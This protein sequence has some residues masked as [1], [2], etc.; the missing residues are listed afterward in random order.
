MGLYFSIV[1]A[2][3]LLMLVIRVWQRRRAG[4]TIGP[5]AAGSFYEM[6]DKDKRSALEVIVEE[7]TGYTD[8]EDRDGNLPDLA[9]PR[10]V[11]ERQRSSEPPEAR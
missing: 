9:E 2:I 1:I 6:L 5:G 11:A 7:R 4:S 8:P 10:S 3:L